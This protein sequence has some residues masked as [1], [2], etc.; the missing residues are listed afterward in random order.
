MMSYSDGLQPGENDPPRILL[1]KICQ[2]LNLL[3]VAVASSSGAVVMSVL[4]ASGTPTAVQKLW[5][6]TN[7]NHV[8]VSNGTSWQILLG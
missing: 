7:N 2:L 5:I 3:F 6:N 1:D 4:D 8:W